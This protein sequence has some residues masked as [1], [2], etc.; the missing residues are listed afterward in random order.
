MGKQVEVASCKAAS[1]T[2]DACPL[3]QQNGGGCIWSAGIGGSITR[4][5]HLRLK[6]DDILVQGGQTH[7]NVWLLKSGFL[8]VVQF[9]RDGR[10]HVITV[11]LPGEVAGFAMPTSDALSVEAA[12]DV[13]LCQLDQ[14]QFARRVSSDRDF[15]RKVYRQ[16]LEQLDRMH[17]LIWSI[18]ALTPEERLA[19]F[20]AQATYYMPSQKMPDG[21]TVL[22]LELPRSDVADLLSTS[23]ETVS[24]FTHRIEGMGWIQ[25]IDPAHFRIL[26]LKAIARLGKVPEDEVE[27]LD[28][29][30]GAVPSRRTMGN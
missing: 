5:G 10:R 16:Q 24:R 11:L 3:G 28:L 9:G 8:R 1:T 30:D 6:R 21:S 29:A 25:I 26:D 7:R 23:P 18:G 22:T 20:F 27:T 14:K 2:C 12:S 13:E 19:A 4:V 15:R 17:W